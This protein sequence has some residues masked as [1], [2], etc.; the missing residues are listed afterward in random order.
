MPFELS[1][2]QELIR[3]TAREF[4]DQTLQPAAEAMDRDA[5]FPREVRQGLT[6]LGFWGLAVPSDHG[7]AGLDAVSLVVALEEL[8]RRS[9]SAA[10][11]VLAHNLAARSLPG[12]V[13]QRA[14]TG[15]VLASLCLSQGPLAATLRGDAKLTG[16]ARLFPL[17]GIAQHALLPHGAGWV[18]VR[19]GERGATWVPEGTMGLRGAQLGQL[20]LTDAPADRVELGFDALLSLG[21]A[22]VAVGLGQAAVEES[23]RF[24][25]DRVQF[26]KPIASFEGVQARLAD[27]A[28]G[29]DAAR[30]LTLQAAALL[31]QGQ[32]AE[33]LAAEAK[34]VATEEASR[35]TRACIR[36]HGG[37]G[38]LKD[39][40][41]ER[42]NRDARM[43][44]LF[45]G[46]TAAQR[47]VAGRALLA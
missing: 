34:V 18:A 2:E 36:L 27:Q 14:A 12:D 9:G 43:L 19:A 35:G 46:D 28:I 10:A 40:A 23:A 21:L 11:A 32:P 3:R 33:R 37:S 6:D 13:A 31:D 4:A 24:A 42:L 38:F 41:A 7:G 22:A 16:A 39:F 17:A 29:I 20:V 8:A 15:E 47:V 26:G 44:P 45:G 30:A 5:R 25:K 1:E